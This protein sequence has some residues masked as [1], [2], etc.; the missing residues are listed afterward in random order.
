MVERVIEG[1]EPVTPTAVL[2]VE[3]WLKSIDHKKKGKYNTESMVRSRGTWC[4]KTCWAYNLFLTTKF[5]AL[6]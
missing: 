6:A 4:L 5:E 3:G 2:A 1:D